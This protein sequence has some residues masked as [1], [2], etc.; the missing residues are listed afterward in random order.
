MANVKLSAIT[1][2]GA[3][4]AATDNFVGVTA[5]NADVLFTRAQLDAAIAATWAN[6]TGAPTTLA[7][8]GITSPLNVAQGGTAAATLTAH[9]VLLGEGTGAVAFATIGTGGNLL[10]DQ[11][12]GADPAFTA[13]SGDATI[14]SAGA[15]S[16]RKGLSFHPGYVATSTP[17]YLPVAFG[18]FGAGSAPVIGTTYL[19][20]VYVPKKIT[21]SSL[22]ARVTTQGA[23]NFQL[24]VYNTNPS[25][26]NRA[27]TLVDHTAS[28]SNNVA[29]G[30]NVSGALGGNQQIEG[31]YFFALQASDTTVRFAVLANGANSILQPAFLG[32]TTLA[33]VLAS[34]GNIFIMGIA[35]T[36]QA[37]G[38]WGDLTGATFTED[39]GA[40]FLSPLFAM[41]IA[42][43]P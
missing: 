41:Q 26:P 12:A 19:T 6:I 4:P 15:I 25:T 30:T 7:G 2:S 33:N 20:L 10:I 35:T 18:N 31:W 11:G 1:A 8:Y 39:T 43:V 32:S 28:I 9:A 29:S 17:W 22:A 37:F 36:A 38:T 24:G 14:T 34:A 16:A 5:A 23:G 13:M 21:I 3:N 27:G 42:S 40:S